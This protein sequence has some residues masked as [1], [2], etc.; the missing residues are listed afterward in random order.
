MKLNL[1]ELNLTIN[2]VSE[3]TG[4][5]TST[6][7]YWEKEFTNYLKIARTSGNTRIYKNDDVKK[8]LTIKD[9]LK[10]KGYTIKGAQKQLGN[11][12]KKA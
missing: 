5:A 4:L 8:I 6:I 3:I 2:Q 1:S 7:R 12:R 10:N 9:L 11:K